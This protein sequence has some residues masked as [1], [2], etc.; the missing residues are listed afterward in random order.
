MN[1]MGILPEF[2]GKAIHD[3]WKSYQS[4][5]C[6]HFLCNAHHL[7]E[8]QYIWEQYRQGWAFQMSLLLV[9]IHQAVEA[10]KAQREDALFQL[11]LAALEARYV[12][13]L[14]QGWAENPTPQLEIHPALLHE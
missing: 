1:E 13:I 10:A 8:L 12:A 6:A 4:Y 11:D 2:A 5:A 7:R 9:S 3:G 14:D